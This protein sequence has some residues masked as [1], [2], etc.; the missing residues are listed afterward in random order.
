[1]NPRKIYTITRYHR[2]PVK[3]WY[4]WRWGA[5]QHTLLTDVYENLMLARNEA[6]RIAGQALKWDMQLENPTPAVSVDYT[7]PDTGEQAFFSIKVHRIVVIP[8]APQPPKKK[9]RHDV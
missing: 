1:M 3:R 5:W 4:G 9:G 2:V 7:H 6:D 8:S